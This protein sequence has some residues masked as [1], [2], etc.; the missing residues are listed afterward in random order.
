MR[1]LGA[2]VVI[3]I[4]LM[5]GVVAILLWGPLAEKPGMREVTDQPGQTAEPASRP[6]VKGSPKGSESKA[7]RTQAGVKPAQAGGEAGP[8]EA[9]P[10]PAGE[11]PGAGT[12][13]ARRTP[14]TFPTAADIAIG[15]ERGRLESSFGK[16]T[17]RTTVVDKGRL[18]ETFVYLQSDLNTAT[19]VLLRNGH[20]VSA[21]TTIY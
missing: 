6:A 16:P 18:L 12:P 5:A 13:A 15:S 10:V 7:A 4:I 3:A 20:V 2:I 21:N 11:T 8:S 19:F 14:H 17:M 1:N 9:G